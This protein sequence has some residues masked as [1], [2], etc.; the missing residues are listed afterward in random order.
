V[1]SDLFYERQDEFKRFKRLNVGAV[2]MET[3]VLFVLGL[4]KKIRTA[5]ILFFDGNPINWK[6]GQYDPHGKKLKDSMSRVIPQV[7]N[8]VLR[9]E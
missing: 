6:E 2:D 1:T 9:S 5:S 3:S 7:L 8:A 4:L